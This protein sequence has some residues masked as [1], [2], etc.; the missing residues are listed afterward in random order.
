MLN[1]RDYSILTER[2]LIIVFLI[3]PPLVRVFMLWRL[4]EA[5]FEPEIIV[6]D[7]LIA[8]TFVCGLVLLVSRM[9]ENRDSGLLF[10]IIVT[11]IS[12]GVYAGALL[13]LTNS[14]E[15]LKSLII[16]NYYLGGGFVFAIAM[17]MFT[18]FRHRNPKH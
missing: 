5:G 6:Y 14:S 3:V 2:N 16:E 15:F 8:L 17:H 4:L 12:I 7:K 10:K 13:G 9:K 18:K 11:Q 1:N